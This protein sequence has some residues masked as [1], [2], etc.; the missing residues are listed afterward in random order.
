[1]HTGTFCLIDILQKLGKARLSAEQRESSIAE[2]QRL[3]TD[4]V[5]RSAISFKDPSFEDEREWR[6]VLAISDEDDVITRVRFRNDAS[7]IKPFV[8]LQLESGVIGPSTTEG[9]LPL[10]ALPVT[11]VMIGPTLQPT[12]SRRA[13][14]FFLRRTPYRDV[15]IFG[16]R[17]PLQA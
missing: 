6:L 12:I 4:F 2:A 9:E 13:L 5:L 17:I 1:M 14:E 11:G 15:D 7:I 3:F 16:S 8:E 10:E